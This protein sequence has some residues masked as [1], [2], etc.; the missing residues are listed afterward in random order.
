M[1]RL[2]SS[3]D[4]A[5]MIEDHAFLL[6]ELTEAIQ[7]DTK[8]TDNIKKASTSLRQ[9]RFARPCEGSPWRS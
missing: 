3:K 9:D 4:A 2:F 5:N 6:E 7:I 1:A 8:Y